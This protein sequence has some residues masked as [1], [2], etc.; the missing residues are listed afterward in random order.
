[1]TF[2]EYQGLAAR[3][4][5]PKLNGKEVLSHGLCGLASET[6]EVLGLF[7]KLFQGHELAIDALIKECGDC[8]WMLAEICT[9]YGIDFDRVAQMNIEKLRARYP[10]GFSEEKSLHRREGD[11]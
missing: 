11:V 7:Q 3:T 4:I 6:G 1:M 9:A 8:L 5:N 2:N 10:E